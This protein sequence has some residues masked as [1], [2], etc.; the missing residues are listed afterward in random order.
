VTATVTPEV[1][2][3]VGY[4]EDGGGIISVVRALHGTGKF[5]C[6]LGM[7]PGAQQHREPALPVLELP[8][9]DGEKISLRHFFRARP[10]AQAVQAWLRADPGRVFHGHSRAGLLVALWLDWFG[11]RRVVVSVHCYGRQRWFYRWAAR[12]LGRRLYWLSPAMREYYGAPGRQWEQCTP[13]GVSASSVTLAQPVRDCLRLGGIGA[14][15]R[16]KGWAHVIAALALLPPALRSR[17]TFTHIGGGDAGCSAALAAQAAAAGLASQVIFR[18]VEASSDALLGEIDALVVA[19]EN[20]PFSMAMLEALAAGVPVLAADSGGS[21]D[22]IQ[23]GV[24]GALY[25]TGDAAALAAQ[26]QLWLEQ[27]PAWDRTRIRATSMGIGQIATRWAKVY[28]EL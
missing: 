17:V 22:L 18:G 12:R 8:R 16:W 2:H 14:R 21:L 24:N 25:R 6:V 13:G 4:D 27:R 9:V 7:N 15:V 10:V 3:Y 20:E 11:E 23:P 19:S 5:V 1:L 28:A 26:L